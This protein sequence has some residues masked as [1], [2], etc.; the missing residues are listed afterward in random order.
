MIEYE[1]YLDDYK[2]SIENP[3]KFWQDIASKY[4]V[5]D[6]NFSQVYSG[7]I[8]SFDNFAHKSEQNNHWFVDGKLNACFNCLDKHLPANKDKIA[9]YSQAD[10]ISEQDSV[11]YGELYLKVCRFA[12][13]LLDLNIKTGDRVCI[14]LPLS[15]EAIVA[16]L[17]CARIGA[18]HS[19]VFAGFSASSLLNRILDAESD[20]LITTQFFVRGGRVVNLID[21]VSKALE[22]E[23]LKKVLFVDTDSG[24]LSQYIASYGNKN[25]ELYD[26][27]QLE[28][29]VADYCPPVFVEASHPLFILYT[30]G[31]TGKP[32]G[33]LHATGGYL[34]HAVYSYEKLFDIVPDKDIYWCSADIGWVTGHSYIVYGPLAHG[35][36]SVI[37][38]GV[39]TFPD[40]SIWWQIIDK[41]NV[42]IFYT[43]PTAIRALM[44]LGEK[45]LESTSRKSLR[46][47]GSVG[48]PI[49]PEAWQWYYKYVG[50]SQCPIVDTWWQTETGA[51]MLAPI[52]N[53]SYKPGCAMLPFYGINLE[54]LDDQQK[55]IKGKGEGNLVITAPWPGMLY[56]VYKQPDKFIDTYFR[57]FDGCFY[58]G[59]LAKR[60]EDGHYWILGRS[61]DVINISGHRLGTAEIE[62]ALVEHKSVSEAAV[63]GVPDELTG[64]GLYAFVIL[65]NSNTNKNELELITELKTHVKNV[66]GPI[67]IIKTI[68]ITDNL[69]KTRSGKIMRRILKQIA[70]GQTEDF[71]DTSTLVDE[72]VVPE[73]LQKVQKY[74]I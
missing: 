66:I 47:L 23:P 31:S 16:M 33:V 34:V 8:S 52:A 27:R 18:I 64:Q 1:Q 30:S 3:T 48:E 37:F 70:L 14:Y 57:V 11:T 29:L 2:Y 73:I 13:V 60:D 74:K 72:S 7:D 5:W 10:Q 68:T 35:M 24:K 49:N 51:V 56:S 32:K 42:T 9:F 25:I 12:N 6:K 65:K 44:R 40:A 62:S 53:F 69:P 36:T 39:P 71:G 45:N 20:L 15:I 38:S 63:I 61:D 17:A 4:I 28:P 22:S 59:D 58:T 50:N 26:Y 41:Y 19:V 43:A 67:A 55:I 54:L 46:I 21:N